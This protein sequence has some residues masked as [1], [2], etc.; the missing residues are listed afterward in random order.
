V[1]GNWPYHDYYKEV[2]EGGGKIGAFIGSR[3]W[4]VSS[5]V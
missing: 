1:S 4:R 3:A 5:A 2:V